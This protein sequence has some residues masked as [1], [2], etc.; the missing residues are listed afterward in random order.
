M[1]RTLCYMPIVCPVRC[2]RHDLKGSVGTATAWASYVACHTQHV[3]TSLSSMCLHDLCV[4]QH[5]QHT[6]AMLHGCAGSGAQ[7]NCQVDLPSMRQPGD[8]TDTMSHMVLSG[9]SSTSAQ[10][11]DTADRPK[12]LPAAHKS[13]P[14]HIRCRQTSKQTSRQQKGADQGSSQPMVMSGDFGSQVHMSLFVHFVCAW[15]MA[16]LTGP[17]LLV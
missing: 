17:S 11:V 15:P 3:S 16:W 1:H 5:H 9:Q 4:Q 12:P 6:H 14:V 7:T 2:N 13:R 10:A 8:A